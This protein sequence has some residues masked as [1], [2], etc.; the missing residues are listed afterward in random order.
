M[1]MKS[2]PG[3]KGASGVP[4]QII[5]QQPPHD[6]YIEPFFGG[7]TI[8]STKRR[9]S[10]NILIDLEPSTIASYSEDKA[11]GLETHCADALDFLRNPGKYGHS[12]THRDLIYCDPP[13]PASAR[14][15]ARDLYTYEMSQA[16]H[17]ELLRLLRGLPCMVQISSYYNE[18]YAATLSDWRLVTFKAR[19]RGCTMVEHLWMNYSE[20]EALHDFRFL[21]I[22]YRERERIARKTK[23]WVQRI[24]ALPAIERLALLSAMSAG[25]SAISGADPA[26]PFSADTASGSGATPLE[27]AH[28]TSHGAASDVQH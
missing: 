21:G 3:G 7:G 28:A 19:T 2:Y 25:M 23:R 4:Q 6:T 27:A 12:F 5:N 10:L 16:Q 13:Y 15:N 26:P 8:Y 11:I 18:L 22:D 24:H 20:P 14:R 17:V 9:A 1:P